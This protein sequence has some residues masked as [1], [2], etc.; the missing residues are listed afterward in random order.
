LILATS[1]V[2]ALYV[3]DGGSLQAAERRR[4]DQHRRQAGAEQAKTQYLMVTG[5]VDAV[6]T[7]MILPLSHPSISL[8]HALSAGG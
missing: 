4:A 2:V 5:V 1:G 6:L 3:A 8:H 7:S